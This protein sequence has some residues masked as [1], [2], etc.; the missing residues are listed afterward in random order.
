MV[1]KKRR[2]KGESPYADTNIAPDTRPGPLNL[3]ALILTCGWRMMPDKPIQL[4]FVRD[5][6]ASL[7]QVARFG[8]P[9]LRRWCG[10]IFLRSLPLRMTQVC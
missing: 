8:Q 5:F 3:M 9:S 4:P 1:D 2:L 6:P 7:R 10:T